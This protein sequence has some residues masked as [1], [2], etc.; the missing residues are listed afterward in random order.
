MSGQFIRATRDRRGWKSKVAHVLEDR[1]QRGSTNFT[2]LM[3]TPSLA[4]NEPSSLYSAVGWCLVVAHMTREHVAA[5]NCECDASIQYC[6]R[7]P[8]SSYENK[9]A[10]Q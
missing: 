6:H 1:A 2:A 7:T 9:R 4:G 8:R 5:R 10:I 3:M